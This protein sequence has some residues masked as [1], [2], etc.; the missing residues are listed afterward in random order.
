MMIPQH[1]LTPEVT[2]AVFFFLYLVSDSLIAFKSAL[3]T[4][5]GLFILTIL[6][7]L[8]KD[9]RPYWIDGEISA[10]ECFFDF[11]GPSYQMF[12]LSFFYNYLIIM[13]CMKYTERP[14]KVLGRVLLVLVFLFAAVDFFSGLYTGQVYIYSNIAG[15]IYGL[16]FLVIAMNFDLEIH[17]MCEKT[18]F[19]LA[20]SRRN[21]FYL[22]FVSMA[23]FAVSLMYYTSERDSWT[24]P[25]SWIINASVGQLNCR[26]ALIEHANNRLGLD[27]S[28]MYTSIIFFPCGMVFGT[29]YSL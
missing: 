6:K 1:I 9:A 24:M 2:I 20:S 28:F 26:V 10:T 8:Y 17:K 5:Y 15:G 11:S 23:L 14:K 13:Y 4:C 22:L 18:G 27:Q 16:I 19:V 29:S 3:L 12:L 21:K 7:M 25:Q